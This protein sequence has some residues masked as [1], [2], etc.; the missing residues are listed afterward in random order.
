MTDPHKKWKKSESRKSEN[1]RAQKQLQQ[2]IDMEIERAHK[3]EMANMN[4]QQK[5]LRMELTKLRKGKNHVGKL[6]AGNKSSQFTGK[7]SKPSDQHMRIRGS[8]MGTRQVGYLPEETTIYLELPPARE[9]TAH[10]P[11]TVE[12]PR[13]AFSKSPHRDSPNIGSIDI[14]SAKHSISRRLSSASITEGLGDLSL[15]RTD[16]GGAH[17]GNSLKTTPA[18]S[19]PQQHA[20]KLPGIS[21]IDGAG[22]KGPLKFHNSNLHPQ[23]DSEGFKYMVTE[24]SEGSANSHVTKN[25]EASENNHRG[26]KSNHKKTR[27]SSI[28]ELIETSIF[29]PE[30]YAPDGTLRM[31]HRLPDFKES[32]EQ[33]QQA[34]YI[35]HSHRQRPDFE[36]Q[37]TVSQIFNNLSKT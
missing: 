16:S 35:R 11:A 33:A 24:A 1:R 32:M 13:L 34:R 30:T 2:R 14:D 20:T 27:R 18:E 3:Y 25:K 12:S 6:L 26:N 21:P 31:L 7:R 15:K 22:T 29:D 37:L 28:E 5:F 9:G 8:K 17:M 10:A 23:K 4:V 19:H 36:R